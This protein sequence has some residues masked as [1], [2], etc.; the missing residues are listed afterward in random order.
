MGK[1]VDKLKTSIH[2]LAHTGFFSV[3]LSN[4]LCKILSFVGGMVIVR[5]LTK[6]EYGEYSYIMNCFGMITL[7]GDLGCNSAA[8]Q[9][10]NEEHK[11]PTK[12]DS[13]FVY[14]Y[15]RG[16][17]F[18]L[19]SCIALLAAPLYYPFQSA[20]AA[21]MTKWLCLMPL[22][23]TTYSFLAVNL[24]IRLENTKYAVIN[25]FHSVITYLVILPASYWIG[26]KGAVISEYIINILAIIVSIIVSRKALKFQTDKKALSKSE[27]RGF[28]KLALGTQLNNSIDTALTLLDVFLIGIFII[29]TEII[30]SY[31][32]A[33][34]I[35]T[36][37][38]FIPAALAIYIVPFFAR[39]Q[40][41]ILWVK[42][43]YY[44]LILASGA[45]NLLITAGLILISPFLIP[46]IFGSQYSDTVTCFCILMIGYFFS[47]T[48][49]IPS[50]NI[51]YTQ[52]KVRVNIII[53]IFSGI[54][55]CILDILFI[56]SLGPIGA[57]IA[58][59]LVHII[60]SCLSFGYMA[61]FLHRKEKLFLSE[62]NDK[63]EQ[64]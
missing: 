31:K 57:A 28:L 43:N 20:S 2:T 14:G 39:N 56:L 53:T 8:L 27:K 37:L 62:G 18:S 6:T 7:L 48:F 49:R 52:R 16:M 51:I 9:C 46:L 15:L 3:F 13:F 64:T 5:I 12:R 26:V 21:E 61:Y 17:A 29:N 47:A 38:A 44:K 36:A 19:L 50:A 41:N 58:T 54:V 60:S 55:H 40:S 32:V 42:R 23:K 35:P 4:T 30:S 33:T 45:L 10:C 22:V 34:T 24:R 63:N 25:V 11:N 1:I 59:T